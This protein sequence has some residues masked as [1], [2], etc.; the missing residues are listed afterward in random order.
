MQAA[1]AES[2]E[3]GKKARMINIPES[4]Q[5]V[6]VRSRS[7]GANLFCLF[8]CGAVETG[9]GKDHSVFISK[10]RNDQRS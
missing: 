2:G 7:L 3:K 4:M 10:D 1:R 5:C 9:G 8:D 6:V